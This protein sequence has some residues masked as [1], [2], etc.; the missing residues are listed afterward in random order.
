MTLYLSRRVQEDGW[1]T[2]ESHPY[3]AHSKRRL[4]ERC[5][6]CLEGL[7]RQLE[8]DVSEIN[9]GPAWDCWKITVVLPDLDRCWAFLGRFEEFFPHEYVY[10]KLGTSDPRRP[11]RV[12]VFH[13]DGIGPLV[14]LLPKVQQCAGATE[15]V[16]D[17]RVS[18]GCADP[19]E[20]LL[21]P[22]PGWQPTSPLRHRDQ[23]PT[24]VTR[25]RTLLYGP[26]NA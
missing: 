18:R 16:L 6:P 21:G 26:P 11:T 4:N 10:G 5:L 13:L 20:H 7:L 12:V 1:T 8:G 17:L 14:R 2:F 19:Y 9:L 23:V 24:V 22:W 3:L 25:L 15:P